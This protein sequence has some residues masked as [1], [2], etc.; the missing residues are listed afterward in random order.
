MINQKKTRLPNDTIDIQIIDYRRYIGNGEKLLSLLSSE[1]KEK[2]AGYHFI[3]DQQRYIVARSL[4]RII[5]SP[6]LLVQP[7]DI[8]FKTQPFGK[9]ELDPAYHPST[10]FFNLSHSEN[11]VAYALSEQP[12]G[13]DIEYEKDVIDMTGIA[14]R[15][16]HPAEN[17][18]FGPLPEEQKKTSF[19][20]L[21]TAKESYQKALGLGMSLPP[22]AFHMSLD[23]KGGA[24][25]IFSMHPS[26]DSW[27]FLS[28]DIEPGY[29]GMV[30]GGRG[31][32]LSYKTAEQL[33]PFLS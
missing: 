33:A 14:K 29:Y 32:Q 20:Q 27:Q 12:V 15:F 11:L 1:E 28:L 26:I 19:F 17:H 23:K 9:P 30:C 22:H 21:W 3:K 16:F 5:L 25:L 7:K 10:L 24:N 13:I 8:Q 6:Y 4:L 31:L 2:A 18:Y